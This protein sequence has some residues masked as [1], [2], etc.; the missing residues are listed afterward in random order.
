MP[1]QKGLAGTGW[2]CKARIV[3]DQEQ[4]Y[5][6]LRLA[7]DRQRKPGQSYLSFKNKSQRM[8]LRWYA[9]A[10]E[11]SDSLQFEKIDET[12]KNAKQRED[13]PPALKAMDR[14]NR[15]I[16]RG[17]YKIRL[18]YKPDMVVTD[19][20]WNDFDFA[21]KEQSDAYK[22]F[23]KVL[24]GEEVEFF[25]PLATDTMERGLDALKAKMLLEYQRDAFWEYQSL[26]GNYV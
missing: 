6:E 5:F 3:I 12:D 19:G 25:I 17:L 18:S 10:F 14:T 8:S 13:L 4:S 24:T 21:S 20:V 16:Q 22:A 23:T 15:D 9:D 2:S 11:R 7:L 1:T 26:N